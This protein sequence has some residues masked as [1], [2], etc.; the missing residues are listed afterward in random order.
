[1]CQ[2]GDITNGDGTGIFYCFIT[3][4]LKRIKTIVLGGESI[5]GPTFPDE[6]YKVELDK[7]GVLA[8]LNKGPNTNS[9]LFLITFI[10]CSL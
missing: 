2:G 4:S 9:S 7:P 10:D 1:M 5:Y 8:M 6:N 3:N